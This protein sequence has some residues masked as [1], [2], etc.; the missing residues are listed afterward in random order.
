LL[1]GGSSKYSGLMDEIGVWLRTLTT[2]EI[3]TLYNNG[4][5]LPYENFRY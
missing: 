5:G 2:E 4:N 3:K 1:G